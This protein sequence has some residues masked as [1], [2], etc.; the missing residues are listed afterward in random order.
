M[1]T[2]NQ[3]KNNDHADWWFSNDGLRGFNWKAVVGFDHKVGGKTTGYQ[4]SALYLFTTSGIMHFAGA[5]ADT[6]A[7]M[8]RE[9]MAKQL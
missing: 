1:A 5:E 2:N 9:K 4:I 8:A 7:Q 6:L 3:M